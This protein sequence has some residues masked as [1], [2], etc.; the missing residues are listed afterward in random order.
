M[1]NTRLM[2]GGKAIC[3]SKQQLHDVLPGTLFG[4]GPVFE[5]AA[6]DE[7]SNQELT[8]F[9]FAGIV[10]REDMRM[11]QRRSH[12]RFALEAAAG[13][14]VGDI[15]GKKL[16]SNGPVESCVQRAIDH[17]HAPFTH[18]GFDAVGTQFESFHLPPAFKIHR[19]VPLNRVLFE[20]YDNSEFSHK[21]AQIPPKFY[22]S[23]PKNRFQN[24]SCSTI[25][26]GMNVMA[27][28]SWSLLPPR[29]IINDH[30]SR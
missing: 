21:T 6:V 25:T 5:S 27:R 30:G 11:I 16:H 20:G 23:R 10:Y 26:D 14:A 17:T 29:R 28:W 12:L 19:S 9:E 22:G 8:P 13:G 3:H 4:A 24:F 1:Q 2:R 15:A 18:L 7:F